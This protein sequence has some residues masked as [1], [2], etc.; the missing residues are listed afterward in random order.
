MKPEQPRPQPLA[1]PTDR[2]ETEPGRS[3]K[4]FVPPL[5]IYSLFVVVAFLVGNKHSC[6]GGG[7]LYIWLGLIGLLILFACAIS[8]PLAEHVGW[9]ILSGLAFVL[10][11]IGIWAWAYDASGQTFMCRLW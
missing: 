1:S 9:R 8:F 2:A 3:P 4:W 5:V 11:G 10:I 7:N 6:D